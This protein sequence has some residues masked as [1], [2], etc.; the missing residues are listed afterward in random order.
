VEK[1]K[2]KMEKPRSRSTSLS[3]RLSTKLRRRPMSTLVDG[4]AAHNMM[5][6]SPVKPN[7]LPKSFSS[8]KIPLPTMT[9]PV[10]IAERVPPVPRTDSRDRLRLRSEP[11]RKRDELWTVFRN[12]DGDLQK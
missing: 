3:R 7:G 6:P 11:S 9:R 10:P 4:S 12:L 1:E 5:P 2:E 8:E